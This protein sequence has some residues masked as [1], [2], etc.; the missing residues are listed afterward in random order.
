MWSLKDL[1][2]NGYQIVK[3]TFFCHYRR[4]SNADS[5]KCWMDQTLVDHRCSSIDVHVQLRDSE[6][7]E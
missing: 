5:N 4:Q 3:N 6:Y 2:Q 7:F 1:V